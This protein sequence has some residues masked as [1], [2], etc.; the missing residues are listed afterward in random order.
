M[1]R[2]LKDKNKGKN[3]N[4]KVSFYYRNYYMIKKK[5]LDHLIILQKPQKTFI[6]NNSVPMH[7][8][9]FVWAAM[10]AGLPSAYSTIMQ[11]CIMEWQIKHIMSPAPLRSTISISPLSTPNLQPGLLMKQ[12]PDLSYYLRRDTHKEL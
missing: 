1:V 8:D 2:P 6:P 4:V 3:L 7:T 12:T 10:G 11:N 5:N 9:I